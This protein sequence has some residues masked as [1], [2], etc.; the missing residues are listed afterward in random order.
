MKRSETGCCPKFDPK[1]WNHKKIA[2]KNKL[3]VKDTVYSLFHL[4]L[5]F[6]SVMKK[7]TKEI[8]K[9]GAEEEFPVVVS[10][11]LSPFYSH[12]YISVKKPVKS[13]HDVKLSG[14]F[15]TK[16]FKGPYKNMKTWIKEMNAYV[17]SKNKVPKQIFFYYTTCPKCAKHYGKNYVVLLAE[18]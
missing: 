8:H 15:L 17:K 18:I 4:P 10:D 14:I 7:N 9:A 16:V 11:E 12:V 2:W 3:F 1:P 6:G 5:N 13:L